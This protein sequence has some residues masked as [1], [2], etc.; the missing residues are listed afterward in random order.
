LAGG[1]RGFGIDLAVDERD[2][3]GSGETLDNVRDAEIGDG[4]AALRMM[5]GEAPDHRAAPVVADPD[6]TL[7]TEMSEQL[8][9]VINAVFERII[10]VGRVVRGTTVATHIWGNA[11]EPER[12]EA[13]ELV[14][15]AM[16][17]LRPAMD[18]DD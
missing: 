14:S 16:R 12:G 18:E 10:G 17:Q 9:H 2:Q 6:S 7:A 11:A 8:E 15:P 13:A 3:L 4:L 5:A 1:I